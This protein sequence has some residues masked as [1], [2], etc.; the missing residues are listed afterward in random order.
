MQPADPVAALATHA[1]AALERGTF[2]RLLL[3]QPV[4]GATPCERIIARLVQLRGAPVLSL[5]LREPRRDTTQNLPP[6]DLPTWLH[7]HLPAQF[8]SAVLETTEKNWQLQPA[9]VGGLKLA[10]HRA[11]QTQVP[12]R[13]HDQAKSRYLDASAHPWLVQLGIHTPDGTVRASMA[14]KYRQLERY[15]EILVHLARDCRW[16]TGDAVTVADMGSGKGYLTFGVWHLLTRHLGLRATVLGIETRSDLVEKGNAVA[17]A[18]GAEGL[19]FSAGTI[20]EATLPNLDALIALHA[21]NTAT[22]DALRRGVGAHARLIL[23]SPCCHQEVR[24]QLGSP[25]PIAP[26]L[27]HGIMAERFS[28]WLTDGLRALH[29]ER[30]GYATKVIEY[31]SSEHTPRNLL[32]AGVRRSQTPEPAAVERTTAEIVRL[33]A[34]A[35]IQ[36][37]ALDRLL[38][39]AP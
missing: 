33:K 16:N 29:L 13:Q 14:D 1:V 15:L 3:S 39:P 10:A 7:A 25:D 2:V 4:A 32:L 8:R 26:I 19:T 34:W 20:A 27:Q 5:T 24:P 28:E 23:L 12:S 38:D 31:V 17:R 30:A 22:D 36:H 21:C 37:H 9:S 18:V 6:G 35:G 11:S